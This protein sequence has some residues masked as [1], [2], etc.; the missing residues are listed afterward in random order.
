MII[1]AFEGRKMEK[2]NADNLFK[3][4][5]T[6]KEINIVKKTIIYQLNIKKSSL[7]NL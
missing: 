2:Y 7:P 1:Q 5:Q 6:F 4:T 3:K